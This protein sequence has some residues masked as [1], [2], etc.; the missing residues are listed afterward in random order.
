MSLGFRPT[1]HFEVTCSSREVRKRLHARLAEMPVVLGV[2][3]IPGGGAGGDLASDHLTLSIPEADR[4]FWS[5]WLNLEIVPHGNGTQLSGRFSP[6][7]SVWT[8][9]MFA[10]L[11]LSVLTFF[12]LVFAAALSMS[13]GAPWTLGLAGLC[14]AAMILLWWASQ[15]GQRLALSQMEELRGI[16]DGALGECGWA[17]QEHAEPLP[18]VA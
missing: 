5:P 6:H 10:Y 4:H 11:A 2:T 16:L 7:P 13:G 15:V 9:F 8:G 18:E 14:V 1:F 17:L 12:A 3:Q